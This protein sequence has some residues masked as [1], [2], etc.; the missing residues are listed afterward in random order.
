YSISSADPK[1][2]GTYAGSLDRP[3]ERVQIVVTPTKAVYT[4]PHAG[5]SGHLLWL[6]ERTLLAQPFDTR[7]LRLEGDPAPLVEDVAVFFGLAAFWASDAGLLAYRGEAK[8]K[9]VWMSRD[10]KRLAEVAPE[11]RHNYVRL[12]PDGLRVAIQRIDASGNQAIWLFEFKRA[13]M[14]RLTFDSSRVGSPVWSPDGRQVAFSSYGA[15]SY[16]IYR[17]DSGGG[18][19]ELLT[20]GSN[21][22]YD[23]D[24][25]R[26]GRYLL[27]TEVAPKTKAD[28]W[29]LPLDGGR[30]PVAV[31]QTPFGEHGGQLSPDGK[32]IAYQSNE[33]GRE[34]VYV[35]PFASGT[36]GRLQI[37]NKGGSR[38]RWRSDGK[39][40]FYLE[41]GGKVMAAA[42]TIT[43]AS[44]QSGSP[45]AP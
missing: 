35:Q 24:W 44:V 6:R 30:K 15:G 5:Q 4:A 14:T 31:V 33:S 9:I 42:I 26:D 11:D 7:T 12:A 10:G 16:Q 22:Q 37:S 8:P 2:Q 20:Q 18:P 1:T 3:Q 25:S 29:V 13:V 40:L 39:E 21:I 41:P 23:L 45:A 36:G 17:K 28:I 19:E 43:P 32:W 38:A 27:Y 34:E